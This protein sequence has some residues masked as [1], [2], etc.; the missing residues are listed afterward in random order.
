MREYVKPAL[1]MEEFDLEDIITLSG[2][3]IVPVSNGGTGQ[4]AADNENLDDAAAPVDLI[5]LN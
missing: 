3:T 2:P 5:N 4:P 1:E